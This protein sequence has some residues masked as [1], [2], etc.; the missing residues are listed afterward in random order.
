FTRRLIRIVGDLRPS[1]WQRRPPVKRV[2]CVCSEPVIVLI[3]TWLLWSHA[4]TKST[5]WTSTR[6][7]CNA[8]SL[9]NLHPFKRVWF[10][11]LQLIYRDCSNRS[12]DGRDLR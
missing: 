11:M 7:H 3:W 10:A 9:V 1:H 6:W 2:H 4:M 5:S 12:N 8:P